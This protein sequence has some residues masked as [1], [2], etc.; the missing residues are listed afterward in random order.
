MKVLIAVTHLLGT[1]HLS[2]ALTLARAFTRDG[3][4]A[5][6]LS[7]GM[8]AE[9]LDKD[10]IALV[11]LPP[12]ASNG[13]DFT[14]LLTELGVEADA[15]Y[16]AKR[17]AMMVKAVEDMAPDVVITELFPFGRRSLSAEFEAL[18]EAAKSL[19]QPALVLASVRDILA[20]PSKA[21]KAARAREV[22]KQYYDGILVHADP[23][24]TKLDMSWPLTSDVT[25]MLR[26]TGYVA[27]PAPQQHPDGIGAGEIVVS[28]G[29]GAVG[30]AL[31]ECAIKAAKRSPLRWR[32]L[33]GGV[34]AEARIADLKTLAD[35]PMIKIEPVRPDFR[36]ML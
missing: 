17:Q 36:Q 23:D 27:P 31:F 22:I 7:G 26:Y 19:P 21:A 28:A 13:V 34:N 15:T 4:E 1:G 5:V 16:L 29:G 10:G 14:K 6:V 12:L 18:L 24:L 33:V 25:A 2:R 32:L 9:H 3:H 35:D 11:Q 30:Q 8:P 20:P